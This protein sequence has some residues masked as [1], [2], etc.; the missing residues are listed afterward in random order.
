M[1]PALDYL[2]NFILYGCNHKGGQS[3]LEKHVG[4][5]YEGVWRYIWIAVL[6]E[7]DSG[8]MKAPSDRVT[9]SG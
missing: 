6:N 4:R 3:R 1:V 2:M 9:L 7:E 8:A 5:E